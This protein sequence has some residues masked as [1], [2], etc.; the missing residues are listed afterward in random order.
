MKNLIR[1]EKRATVFT[2]IFMLAL[3]VCVAQTKTAL[4]LYNNGVDLQQR[5]NYYG[6]VDAF[7]E[8]LQLNEHYGD[9][10]FHLA[11]CTYELGEYD[12]TVEYTNNAEKY[13]HNF[14][15]IRNL[16]GMAYISLG[17]LNDARTVFNGVLK[18][19]PNDVNSRFGLAQLDLFDGSLTAAE[20]RYIDALKRQNTN[21]TALLS[22]ALISAEMGKNEIAQNYIN[23]ALAYHSGEAQVHYLASYLAAQQGDF[24]DAERR[25]RSAVQLRGDYDA[26]YELLA[27]ILYAQKRYSEVI[28]MCDFRIG[29]E[30]NTPD[31]WYLKGLAQQRLGNTKDAISTFTT[32]ISIAP[33][34]EV[35]RTALEE[36]VENNVD[37]ED[38]RRASW[39]QYHIKKAA[40]YKRNY[41]G[42]SERF[43]YQQAL[44]VDPLNKTARQEFANMLNRDGFYELYLLQLKFL[45]SNSTTQS[46]SA[47]TQETQRDENTPAVK[48]T[49]QEI[50]NSD[51]I[52]ALDSMMSDSLAA[53]W[54]VDPFY[55]DKTRWRIGIYYRKS[56]IQLIHS[57]AEQITAIA[58]QKIFSGVPS[59]TVDVQ[60][61]PVTGYGDAFK[62]ARST[63]RDYFAIL[64][65]SET[66]RSTTLDADIYSARTG[67]LTT[68]IHIYRTGND[69]Y[70]N[71]LRRFRQSLLDILPVRGKILQHTGETLLVDLGKSDGIAKDA[72]FDVV[73]QGEIYTADNGTGITYQTDSMLGT[74]T[75]TVVNEEI[76]EGTFTKKGYYDTL[77]DGDEVVLINLPA[78]GNTSNGNSATDTKPAADNKGAPATAA[79]KK[80]EKDSQKAAEILKVPGNAKES[81]LIN[82]I[83]SI[84]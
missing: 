74:F 23:Q 21:K 51:T 40:E 8:A 66:E 38:T 18:E 65:M 46:T 54:N 63:K 20:N 12:L 49:S 71:V 2:V 68:K 31:A 36:L 83:R 67:T 45:S 14:C 30:R 43:E 10:W 3:G 82:L 9:A 78:S 28:D 6:A 5:E 61:E 32:G 44:K 19:Y 39:A 80:E 70:A 33:Q 26:A 37:V 25:A 50:K 17:K 13:S 1:L 42:P 48:K 76:S 24:V 16:R 59:T 34:D 27:N 56:P 52:E 81:V 58:A 29:R 41:D 77:N 4:S 7:R 75:T 73:K 72:H 35:M 79:A 57:D 84:E 60:T 47:A 15:D 22:L 69:R 55:L 53:K 11:Q 62:Q 64:S